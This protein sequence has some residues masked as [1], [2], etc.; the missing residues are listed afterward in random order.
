MYVSPEACC[1]STWCI[2][3]W[4]V[5]NR[6]FT[7]IKERWLILTRKAA[8]LVVL[9]L[10][11]K[12]EADGFQREVHTQLAHFSRQRCRMTHN[13]QWGE[14]NVVQGMLFLAVRNAVCGVILYSRGTQY[15]M[16]TGP[17]GKECCPFYGVLFLV[18]HSALNGVRFLVERAMD[19]EQFSWWTGM[20]NL[21]FVFQWSWTL[22]IACF[23]KE[24]LHV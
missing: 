12:D 15:V 22:S 13:E 7:S 9:I 4:N 23:V 2:Y 6:N 11:Q 14:K 10:V 3:N 5:L 8:V 18:G 1:T 16:Y 20:L 24:E 19:M 21:A 17:S